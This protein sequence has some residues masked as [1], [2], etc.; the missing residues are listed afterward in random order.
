MSTASLP[1][2]EEERLAE[3][4]RYAILDT[5]SE[6]NFDNLTYL[7]AHICQSPVSL[8]S[9]VD[10]HRLWFKSR[11]GLD[12]AELPRERA[13]CSYAICHKEPFIVSDATK[14]FLVKDSPL[15]TNEPKIRFYA[16][17][18]LIS[19]GGYTLGVLCVIDYVPRE[20]STEQVEVLKIIAGQ[21]VALLEA[22]LLSEKVIKYTNALEESRHLEHKAFHDALTG[23]AN[24]SLFAEQIN[25]AIAQSQKFNCSRSAVL[26]IDLNRFKIVNDSLGHLAGDKLLI[27]V[28]DRLIKAVRAIDLVARLGGDEFVVLLRE[29][30]DLNESIHIAKRIIR[31]IEQ[32]FYI[33]S[34]KIF[35]SASV[36]IVGIDSNYQNASE[37]IRDADIAMY[38]AKSGAQDKYIVFDKSMHLEVCK[39]LDLENEL[40]KALEKREFLLYYQPIF[41][42][43]TKKIVGFEALVRWRDRQKNIRVPAKFVRVAEETGIIIPLGKWILAEA[44]RQLKT[45][46]EQF[47][48]PQCFSINVN[49]S[50]VQLKDPHFLQDI[51][52]ILTD[53]NLNGRCL[54]LEITESI[55]IEDAEEVLFI[56]DRLRQ[57]NISVS[58][59]D[60]GTG[61]SSLSYLH[62]F[63]I[64]NLKIDKSFVRL[65]VDRDRAYRIIETIA[66]LAQ[67][68]QLTTIAEGVEEEQQLSLLKEIGCNYAQGYLFSKPLSATAA[69]QWLR[70]RQANEAIV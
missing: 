3:L 50:V 62:R 39:R 42:L 57:R 70:E 10:K 2:N 32:P 20:I 41:S 37:I 31:E 4:Y 67:Q 23:L 56:L 69:T 14:D 12:I 68:L 7:A 13:F 59:D 30:N 66:K 40:R 43:E 33:F 1:E 17:V 46:Q 28:A 53:T 48:S 64:S 34:Q 5:P 27:E 58:I 35:V 54:T 21:V 9:L 65:M 47:P 52:R 63:S 22:R 29:I 24:R 55:L 51:D 25:I 44:C 11:Y 36:G 16:A 45:W 61:Y 6:E 60:F 19:S 49:I 15:V 8:I 26:F 18:P 38:R